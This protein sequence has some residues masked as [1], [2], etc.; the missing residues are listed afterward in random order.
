MTLK[1][2]GGSEVTYDAD[3][4]VTVALQQLYGPDWNQVS[5]DLEGLSSRVEQSVEDS[6]GWKAA[7]GKWATCMNSRYHVTYADPQATRGDV[8]S[9]AA[10]A[11]KDVPAAVAAERLKGVRAGEIRLAQQDAACQASV[12]LADVARTAQEQAQAADSTRYAAEVKAY[13]ADF[14]HAEALADTLLG[15]N[16]PGS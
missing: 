2:V 15:K 5:F 12:G 6:A 3:G 14:G 1:L 11:I 16:V 9:V 7:V 13:T 8:S 4:C 10:A